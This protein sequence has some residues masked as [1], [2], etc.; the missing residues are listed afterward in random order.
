MT[1]LGV[2]GLYHVACVF[3]WRL[4]RRELV[5]K[6]MSRNFHDYQ[7]ARNIEKTME[8]DGPNLQQ[9]IKDEE[10]LSEDLA[11]IQGFGMN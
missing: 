1:L 5:N 7:F 3:S 4:E 2:L 8:S 9:G 11:P 6:L 10:A